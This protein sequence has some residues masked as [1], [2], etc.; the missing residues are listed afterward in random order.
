MGVGRRVDDRAMV[1]EEMVERN[2]ECQFEE[3]S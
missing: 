3:G 1:L 2:N